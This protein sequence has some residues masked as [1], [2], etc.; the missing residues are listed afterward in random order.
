ME[1][2]ALTVDLPVLIQTLFDD[3][4]DSEKHAAF[5]GSPAV[6][7]ARTGGKFTA[8]DGYI[9][10]KTLE[11][12]PP[13]R[14]LQSWRTTEFAADDADSVL[15]LLFEPIPAGTRLT[16]HHSQI[17]DGQAGMYREGWE[18]YYFDPMLEYYSSH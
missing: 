17:P 1:T 10:G 8:W 2:L 7:D 6:I 9:S 5:T 11:I 4:L 15:E 14:I 18:E 16:L 3:W 13:R 12:E